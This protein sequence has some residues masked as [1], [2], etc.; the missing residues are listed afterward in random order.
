V[1]P[2]PPQPRTSTR[3]PDLPAAGIVIAR[4]SNRTRRAAATRVPGCRANER[5]YTRRRP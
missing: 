4:R 5:R 1:P 2:M 3:G